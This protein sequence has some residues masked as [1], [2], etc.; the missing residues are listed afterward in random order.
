VKEKKDRL[1]AINSQESA[2]RKLFEENKDKWM[3]RRTSLAEEISA[4]T[5]SRK[6]VE[7]RRV[8]PFTTLKKEKGG[9]EDKKREYIVI[10]RLADMESNV[11]FLQR[12]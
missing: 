2:A 1:D 3:E 10:S 4:A 7:K 6:D 11:S 12:D 8:N 9:L 5:P